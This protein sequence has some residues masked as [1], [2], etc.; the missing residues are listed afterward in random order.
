VVKGAKI[1]TTCLL[2]LWLGAACTQVLGIE[3][4]RFDTSLRA[5]S[6]GN[7]GNAGSSLTS[8]GS[9]GQSS[10]EH[11]TAGGGSGPVETTDGGAENGPS[12]GKAGSGGG[13][14]GSGGD[15]G[16][17]TP[18][19]TLCE[20]YCDTVMTNCKG[21]YEQYRTFDQC[22]EVCKRLPPG[23]SGDQDVNSVE[24]RVRQA[25]FASAEPFVYCKS[26]GPLGAGKCGSNCVSFCSLMQAT[27]TAENTATNVEPSFYE[28]SQA[29]LEACGTI[30]THED[31]PTQYSTSA[32]VEPSCFVG[33]TVY[34]RAYHI[35]SALEQDA[36]DEHC[37]H[38][39]GG[40]PC[41]EQ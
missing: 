9:A 15:D 1:A 31:D 22:V 29:C 30:P 27:C 26:A 16:D 20:S 36:P 5:G 13:S 14:V 34:C 11:T 24:C 28:S 12:G 3:D 7:G 10:H 37:P 17:P 32:T 40:D 2:S 25:Q 19:A 6:S 4:A 18:T 33:N 35:A 41:I 39:R 8:G 38:A 23:S 21:K